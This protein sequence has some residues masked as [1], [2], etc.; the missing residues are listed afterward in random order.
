MSFW[1]SLY[2]VLGISFIMGGMQGGKILSKEE[3]KQENKLSINEIKPMQYSFRPENLDQYIGQEEAKDRIKMCVEQCL[4]LNPVHFLIYGAKGHGKT[5]LAL[6]IAKMLE[7]DIMTYVGNSFTQQN[8]MDFLAKN[9]ENSNG[10][11][12]FLDEVHGLDKNLADYM[13]PIIEQFILPEGNLKLKPFVMIGC[14]T[15]KNQLAKKSEPFIDRCASGDIKLEHYNA[16]DIKTILKQ[17]NERVYQKNISEE[18]YDILANNTR[19]NPRTATALF[20][21]FLICKDIDKVLKSHKIIKN[22]LTKDDILVL[23]HLVE[24]G[25]PVGVEVLAIITQQTKQDYQLLQ[26]PYLIQQ[27]YISRSAK[28]RIATEKAKLL[29]QGLNK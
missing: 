9:Q 17:L 2:D 28:G 10:M 15:D 1:D 26:E 13:L 11:V 24:I 8:L 7:F 20:R 25:K 23:K 12:L 6:I 29:L 22:S 21:D 19:F 4:T 14:T 16:E 5:T 18:V 27:G 3:D